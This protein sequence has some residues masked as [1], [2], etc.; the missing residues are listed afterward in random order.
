MPTFEIDDQACFNTKVL[1]AGNEAFGAWCRAGSWCMANLTDGRVTRDVARLI[2]SDN[3]WCALRDCGSPGPGLVEP[4]GDDWQIHD[5]DHWQRSSVDILKRREL[6]AKRQQ[7]HRAMKRA[8]GH[9]TRDVPRD[10]PR[11]KV[12]DV[13]RESRPPLPLPL[14]IRERESTN[15][16]KPVTRDKVR[17]ATTGKKPKQPKI[18][19]KAQQIPIPDDWKPIE[20]HYVRAAELG[21][22]RRWVDDKADTVRLWAEGK[23]DARYANWDSMFH[24]WLKRDAK[25]DTPDLGDDD[26]ENFDE[27]PR[28]PPPDPPGTKYVEPEDVRAFVAQL[29]FGEVP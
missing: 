11:D 3:V 8:Q 25:T 28:E 21:F 9:V 14:P 29:Q 15:T 10:V 16:E 27:S 13:P 1:R 23:G 18:N 6:Q 5:W 22:S 7:N 26:F 12:C 19:G 24:N 20:A 2:A 4:L 17:D